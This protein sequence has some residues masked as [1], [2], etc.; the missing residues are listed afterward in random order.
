MA[1]ALADE[2]DIPLVI[3]NDPD[4]DRFCA[5][6]RTGDKWHIFTGNEMGIILAHH[7]F[8]WYKSRPDFDPCT[9]LTVCANGSSIGNVIISSVVKD[10]A[11]HGCKGGIPS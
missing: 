6:E 10:V 3:A 11:I 8:T 4:A 2:E 5:A 7:V 1:I 9:A